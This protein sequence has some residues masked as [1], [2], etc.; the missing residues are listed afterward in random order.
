MTLIATFFETVS[1][2]E[3]MLALIALGVIERAVATSKSARSH[4][5]LRSEA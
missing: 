1:F 5:V 3:V 4:T 2:T